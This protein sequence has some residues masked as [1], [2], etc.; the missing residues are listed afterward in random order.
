MT[1]IL[2]IAVG[3]TVGASLRYYLTLWVTGAIGAGFPYATLL[4]NLSGSFIL[5]SFLAAMEGNPQFSANLRLLVATG[6]CGS[7]TTF[8]TLS[9]DTL[10]L[11]DT[12]RYAA[13]TLNGLGSLA[14]GLLA[15]SVGAACGRALL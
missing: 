6:F 15:A 7:F 2:L 11:L 8:S 4:I 14:L 1:T 5:G 12:G 3:A 10:A 13:A 9:Y